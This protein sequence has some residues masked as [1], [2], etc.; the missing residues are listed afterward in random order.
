[1]SMSDIRSLELNIK[2]SL[3]SRISAAACSIGGFGAF[4]GIFSVLRT[5]FFAGAGF[6]GAAAVSVSFF[7][8]I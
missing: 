3:S 4:F 7:Y 1:M 5:R 8:S 2:F 6:E